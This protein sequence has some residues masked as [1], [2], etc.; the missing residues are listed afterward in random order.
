MLNRRRFVTTAMS[1]VIAAHLP[2]FAKTAIGQTI[3]KPARLIVGFPAGGAPDVV[4]R[5]LAEHMKDYA[6]SVIV[7]NR[8]GAGGRVA[9]ETLKGAAADGSV[10]AFTPIDQL[11]LFPHIYTQLAYKPLQDFAPV[12]TVCAAQFLITIGSRVPA[13]VTT[14]DGFVRWCRLNPQAASYGTAGAGTLPHFL[15]ISFARAAGVKLVH[16]PYKGGV[17]VIQDVLGGHVAACISTIGTL[18]PSVQ[19]GGLRALATTAPRRSTALP[20]VPTF[21]EAGYP[22][23][24]SLSQFGLLVPARTPFDTVE[25]LHKAVHEA[26]GTDVVKAGLMKLSLEPAQTSPAEFAQLIASETRRW[27]EIVKASGFQPMD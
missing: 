13:Q 23:V 1:G 8:P 12:T 25:R 27:A 3:T 20:D 4:A 24:E 19:N 11:A 22:T 17:T 15:G 9:L 18:L 6:S 26:L 21:R 16:V 7:D 5:L 10:M 2:P 14:I